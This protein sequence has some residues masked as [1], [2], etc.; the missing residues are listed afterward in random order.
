MVD[1]SRPYSPVI[2]IQ[3]DESV[4]HVRKQMGS[5]FRR[6]IKEYTGKKLRDGKGVDGK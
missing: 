1:K 4:N 2:F 6:P 5:N 3:N